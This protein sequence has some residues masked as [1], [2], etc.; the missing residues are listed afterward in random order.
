MNVYIYSAAILCEACGEEKRAVIASRGKAPHDVDDETTY[1]TEDFP[2]GPYPDGGG[3][4]DS[5]QH[6]DECGSFLENPLTRDGDD[7]VREAIER[8]IQHGCA[9]T[10]ALTE[11]GP[12]YRPLITPWK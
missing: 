7:Y 6:C 1:D 12:F 8:D 10:A 2:K 4:A 5:P 3:E 11:W 9:N